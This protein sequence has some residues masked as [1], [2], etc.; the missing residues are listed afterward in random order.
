VNDRPN[1]VWIYCDELRPDALGCYGRPE[2][3][4]HT[5]NLDR[6][7]ESGVRFTNH[8]C[9]SPICVS[10]LPDLWSKTRER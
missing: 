9:N 10:S 3:D 4:L 8:F 5:P 7:A 1:I 2:L 6:L